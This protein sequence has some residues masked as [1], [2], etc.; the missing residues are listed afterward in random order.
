MSQTATDGEVEDVL[1][2]TVNTTTFGIFTEPYKLDCDETEKGPRSD[3]FGTVPEMSGAELDSVTIDF[4]AMYLFDW[5]ANLQEDADSVGVASLGQAMRNANAT[6]A[7]LMPAYTFLGTVP[8]TSHLFGFA[9]HA[10]L[11]HGKLS[12]ASVCSTP[13]AAERTAVQAHLTEN[14]N[15]TTIHSRSIVRGHGILMRAMMPFIKGSM[16]AQEEK[17]LSGLKEVIEANQ[18]DYYP[19]KTTS[20][21]STI[22]ENEKS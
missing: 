9:Q 18:K 19:M 16:I 21:D 12:M 3:E 10:L 8:K 22:I 13:C 6:A 5:G 20:I 4:Y 11:A 15:G 2:S 7:V 1:K 14:E 17:N